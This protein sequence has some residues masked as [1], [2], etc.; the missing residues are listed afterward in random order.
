[1]SLGSATTI[2]APVLRVDDVVDSLAQR[3]A[4]CDDVEGPQQPG[5]LPFRK[6]LKLIPR[7]R[8]HQVKDAKFRFLMRSA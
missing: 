7:Q 5:V 1:M 3:A 6:L 4:R 8:R 2:R